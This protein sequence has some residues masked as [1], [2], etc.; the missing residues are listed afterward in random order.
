MKTSNILIIVFTLILALTG[1]GE[2]T[3][4]YVISPGGGFLTNGSFTL[5]NTVGEMTMIQT[6]SN[7]NNSLTQGF[8]QPSELD[9]P[10]SVPKFDEPYNVFE[11]FPNPSDGLFYFT[12]NSSMKITGTLNIYEIRGNVIFTE[13]FIHPKDIGLHKLNLQFMPTG[14]YLLEV[15][16]SNADGK[17]VVRKITKIIINH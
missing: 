9:V 17:I 1:V 2:S 10:V 15:I 14:I 12:L 8:Q 5:S 7:G 16:C 6:F 11:V 3:S 13:S 4:P